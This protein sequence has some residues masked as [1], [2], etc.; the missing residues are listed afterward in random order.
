M[1][2]CNLGFTFHL[3]VAIDRHTSN[4]G[5]L[6]LPC[7]LTIESVCVCGWVGVSVLNLIGV[8]KSA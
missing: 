1:L 7:A 4:Y 6:V 2:C 8:H 3:N 5:P